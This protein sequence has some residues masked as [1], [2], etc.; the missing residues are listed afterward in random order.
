MKRNTRPFA[1]SFNQNAYRIYSRY[2]HQFGNVHKLARLQSISRGPEKRKI[3]HP[4]LESFSNN[5]LLV[6]VCI[7]YHNRTSDTFLYPSRNQT[8]S[9]LQH[10]ANQINIL[11]CYGVSVYLGLLAFKTTGVCQLIN[12]LFKYL[13]HF[14]N[15]YMSKYNFEKKAAKQINRNSTGSRLCRSFHDRSFYYL[16]LLSSTICGTLSTFQHKSTFNYLAMVYTHLWLV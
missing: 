8:I 13:P 6:L 14:K 3:I 9:V 7:L 5:T 10:N 4:L 15:K 11:G 16:R 12:G 1:F 2:I